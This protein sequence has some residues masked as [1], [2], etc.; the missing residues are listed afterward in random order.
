MIL[1]ALGLVLATMVAVGCG[2]DVPRR[3]ERDSGV[4]PDSGTGP[5]DAGSRDGGVDP[6]TVLA[7]GAVVVSSCLGGSA[8]ALLL[9]AYGSVRPES[10][11]SELLREQGTC[12]AEARSGC[13]A[14]DACL[15]IELD[16]PGECVAG[17]DGSTAILC[18]G[19]RHVRWRCADLG[20]T[21]VDGGCV[22]AEEACSASA[23]DGSVPVICTDG[24]A[25][26]GPDCAPLGLDC[27]LLDDGTPACAGRGEACTPTV[28]EPPAV[29]FFGNAIECAD[30]EH[31]ASCV[32][33][34]RHEIACADVLDGMTCR[35]TTEMT[36][37]AFCGLSS[38]CNPLT[39][40]V[41]FCTGDEVT[42][43]NAG[44][45]D[46]VSCIELGF[47]RCISGRCE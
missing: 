38:E 2:D 45:L 24:V 35:T 37:R 20:F 4:R 39:V 41:E 36:P 44:R 47:E 7:R 19:G 26:R 31:L 6:G 18:G 29:D 16:V 28:S 12:L 8:G 14:V 33:G 43:C 34:G 17:C 30:R 27:A 15:G 3:G 9:S 42:V 11:L 13:D 21:C 23:C 25:T 46:R 22:P 10:G 1:R 32:H 5:F 40:V